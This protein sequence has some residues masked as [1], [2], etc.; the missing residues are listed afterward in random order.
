[1]PSTPA[2]S[3]FQKKAKNTIQ[4]DIA[5]NPRCSTAASSC[6]NCATSKQRVA[7]ADDRPMLAT[8]SMSAAFTS[9]R[10][11]LH[12]SVVKVAYYQSFMTLCDTTF[13]FLLLLFN[14]HSAEG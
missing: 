11:S 5:S 9:L 3:L 7:D 13:R 12:C 4:A 6:I 10:F 2:S 8:G 1:G 14:Q